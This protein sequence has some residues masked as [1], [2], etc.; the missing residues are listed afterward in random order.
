MPEHVHLLVLP[1]AQGAKVD[2][3]LFAIKRPLGFRVKQQLLADN[4]P[5]AQRL[6]V[7]QRP[8]TTTFR[9]WQ[10][11][12]GYDRNIRSEEALQGSIEYSRH[13]QATTAKNA[14]SISRGRRTNQSV[15]A[16]FQLK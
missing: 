3:L 13:S 2:K 8:G 9:F 10:E 6:T 5:L 7:R 1:T 11:G 12:P 16:S 14:A 4:D 15:E